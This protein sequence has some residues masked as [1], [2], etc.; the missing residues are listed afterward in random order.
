[1]AQ[2]L[3]IQ[4]L[5]QPAY[6]PLLMFMS[7]GGAPDGED[8]MSF[9]STEI[10]VLTPDL[11]VKTLAFGAGASRDKL[12][13]LADLGGGELLLAID[14]MALKECFRKTAASLVT[15]THFR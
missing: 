9:L 8:E 4:G 7:D 14:G 1:M 12:Q 15:K 11:Q 13:R 3:L 10:S 2:S 5:Q 6:S